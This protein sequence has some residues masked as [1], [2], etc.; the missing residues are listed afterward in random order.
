MRA[1]HTILVVDDHPPNLYVASR[2]L[3]EAGYQ[4]LEATTGEEALH[5]STRA[6]GLLMDVNL[7]D[8]NGVAVC[9]AVRRWSTMPVVLM[10]AAFRDELHR[11]AGLDAGADLYLIPPL[12]GIQL[13]SSFDRLLHSAA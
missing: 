10:S 4:V 5:L 7:P 6:S 11:T 8:M 1:D 13:A 9:Q 2:L 12:D 3:K